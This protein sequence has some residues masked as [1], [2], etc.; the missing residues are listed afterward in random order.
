MK[1]YDIIA[2]GTGSAMNLISPVIDQF[3]DI[4]VAVVENGPVGG[5]CLTRGCIPSKMI[6]Y[7]AE[8][9]ETIKRAEQFGITA[10]IENIDFKK[11][12]SSMRHTIN[13][14]SQMI[15]RGLEGS[16]NI[17]F[18]HTTGEFIGDYTLRVGEEEIRGKTILIC[19]GSRPLIP[20]IKGVK[21][22]GYLTSTSFL[23]MQ[24]RPAS[25]AIIGGG[26]IA[27]EY[28]HFMASMGSDVT[29]IGR[30]QQF[31]PQEEPEVSDLLLRKL[32]ERM[33]IHT[34]VEVRSVEKVGRMKRIIGIRKETGEEVVVDAEEIL[35]AT[36]R[37]SYSKI[38]KPE[39]SGVE[40]DARG[41]IKV[42]E[43]METSKPNIWSFGD[44][45]GKH[46]F[47]HVA[48]VE[49]QVAFYN[50]YTD[51]KM[52]MDYHAVPSAVFTDPEVASV[53]MRE[54]EAREGGHRILIGKYLYENTAKGQA[55]GAKDY[56]VK[57]IVEKETNRILG[58]HIIGPHAS[59]LIQEIINLMNTKDGSMDP[60]TDGMHIHPALTEVVERAFLNL[61]DPDAHL[62]HHS[63]DH[64]HN[65]AHEH[66]NDHEG[67]HR[68]SQNHG[69][70]QDHEHSPDHV[71]G[72]SGHHGDGQSPKH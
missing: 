60:L 64:S 54:S 19:S 14:D 38:L 55:M 57:V 65:H 2:I 52:E 68:H 36:G 29:I 12:M 34:G 22:T 43:R 45:I 58:A 6:L 71:G 25:I 4:R 59:I 61:T 47:K 48:N 69:D 41:W 9:I 44:A 20:P 7:P 30:N 16:S 15:T 62:H 31:V 24:E 63:D 40:T 50:I 66:S 3:P 21:E 49:A 42:N 56:F 33:T 17:D 8:I 72:R 5:I 53:G 26:Y 35:I 13:E 11:I 46:L 23:K 51:H 32:S 1:E 67:D 28:G 37:S 10:T 70:G 18:Y 27:A 39:K